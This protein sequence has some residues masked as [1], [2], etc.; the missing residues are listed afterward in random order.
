LLIAIGVRGLIAA[1]ATRDRGRDAQHPRYDLRSIDLIGLTVSTDTFAAGFGLGLYG[2][3]IV[4]AVLVTAAATVL[5]SWAGFL[6]GS[7]VALRLGSWGD[8]LSSMALI[9]IGGALLGRII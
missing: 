4:A 2:V 3:P 5:M 6:L 9:L 7:A 8:R 1:I